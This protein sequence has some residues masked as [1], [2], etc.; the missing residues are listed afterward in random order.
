MPGATDLYF[1]VEDNRREVAHMR[2]A[3]LRV[4]PSDW[5]HRAGNPL[6]SVA[7]TRFIDNALAELLATTV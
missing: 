1:Q 2:H 6:H 4:I 5:G 3:E 7:D